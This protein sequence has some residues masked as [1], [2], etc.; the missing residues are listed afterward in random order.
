MVEYSWN[1]IL[2]LELKYKH[3]PIVME[4]I[5]AVKHYQEYDYTDED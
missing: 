4:L 3:D 2:N 5:R 1:D